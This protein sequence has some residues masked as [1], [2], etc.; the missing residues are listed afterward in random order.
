M[1]NTKKLT[2]RD[3]TMMDLDNDEDYGLV[4]NI[5]CRFCNGLFVNIKNNQFK[6]EVYGSSV[7]AFR[8]VNVKNDNNKS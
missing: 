2:E 7:S 3:I 8:K 4:K 1:I 5:K 6:N